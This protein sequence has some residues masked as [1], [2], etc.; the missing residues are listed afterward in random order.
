MV[1]LCGVGLTGVFQSL[2]Q[3]QRLYDDSLH[4]FSTLNQFERALLNTER[5]LLELASAQHDAVRTAG[6]NPDAIRAEFKEA[7]AEMESASQAMLEQLQVWEST[8][9]SPE[10]FWNLTR[11][12]T[13]WRRIDSILG[14]FLAF[15]DTRQPP[16]LPTLRA[17]RH[18]SQDN[19][20]RA[21]GD[22][23]RSLETL[24]V[25][26]QNALYRQLG[27]YGVMSVS[28]LLGLFTLLYWRWVLPARRL[29]ARLR[30]VSSTP[31]P[32]LTEYEQAQHYIRQMEE[33]LRL[34]EQFMRDLAMGRT[35][36]PIAPECGDDALARSS[37]WLLK[38]VEEYRRR[39]HDREAV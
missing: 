14:E 37:F 31:N 9:G 2:Q 13:E 38:R 34:V 10:F 18:D 22:L 25:Q 36:E 21:L 15:S 4:T 16:N 26:K 17:F 32:S 7:F 1:V 5:L 24:L 11:V 12:R 29:R 27:E 19:L 39:A 20:N 30:Q 8:G 3:L 35:P 23:H 6:Y 33:C 28:G